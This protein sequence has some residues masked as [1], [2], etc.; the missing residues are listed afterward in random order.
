MTSH[1]GR[2]S[3]SSIERL[4]DLTIQEIGCIVSPPASIVD[5]GAGTG[6]L[7]IPLAGAGYQVTAVEPSGP[8]LDQLRKAPA[9]LDITSIKSTMQDFSTEA[10]FDLAIC[11]FTV[12]IIC[13][14]RRSSMRRWSGRASV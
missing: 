7:S 12:V 4:T 11:V 8:M 9:S 3:G 14:T 13:W 5:F 1:T 6:R 2:S 10:R